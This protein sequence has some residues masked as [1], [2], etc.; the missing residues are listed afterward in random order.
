MN[1]RVPF[2]ALA[3]STLSSTALAD[4]FA[5]AW[6]VQATAGNAAL[7]AGRGHFGDGLLFHEGSLQSEAFAML[8]FAPAPYTV[9]VVDGRHHFS[10][11]LSSTDRGTLQ[12]SGVYTSGRVVG[13]L[14]WTRANGSQHL[15]TIEAAR[16]DDGLEV[17]EE[18][19]D[20]AGDVRAGSS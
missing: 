3:I 15:Y 1:W 17:I 2:V 14:V 13:T 10:A 18:E 4:A 8:G 16:F 11:L 9:T 19:V 12:W 6:Q 20:D 7:E 5:G